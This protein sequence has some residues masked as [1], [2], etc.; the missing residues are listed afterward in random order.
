MTI[1]KL[2]RHCRHLV[3]TMLKFQTICSNSICFFYQLVISWFYIPYEFYCEVWKRCCKAGINAISLIVILFSFYLKVLWLT[4]YNRAILGEQSLCFFALS[5]VY[6]GTQKTFVLVF[7]R[8]LQGVLIKTNIF[9]LVMHPQKTFWLRPIYSS[10]PYVFD[11]SSSLF[12]D[13]LPRYI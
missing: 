7:R 2:I 6:V 12:Q 8:H 11:T 9:A 1:S 10:W 13:V 4:L 5:R 3:V